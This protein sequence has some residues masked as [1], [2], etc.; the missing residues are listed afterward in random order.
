VTFESARGDAVEQ[1]MR[2]RGSRG[3]RCVASAAGCERAGQ[4]GG[5]LTRGD[6]VSAGEGERSGARAR[7]GRHGEKREAGRGQ[8]NSGD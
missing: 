6:P 1:K 2:G 4:R 8:M 7:V 5:A 3:G